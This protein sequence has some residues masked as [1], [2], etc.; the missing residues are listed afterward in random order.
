[1]RQLCHWETMYY[2]G[3][4]QVSFCQS[5]RERTHVPSAV[6]VDFGVLL[7]CAHHQVARM[8]GN[9]AGRGQARNLI[10]KEAYACMPARSTLRFGRHKPSRPPCEPSHR[11]LPLTRSL[12]GLWVLTGVE[13]RGWAPREGNQSL[14]KNL[15]L[16]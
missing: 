6:V 4:L 13:R 2:G 16:A 10:A 14:A 12:V 3:A 9:L 5:C 8:H 7:R 11:R 1:M 15:A